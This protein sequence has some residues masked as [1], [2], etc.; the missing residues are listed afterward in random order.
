M[1]RC[2]RRSRNN[3]QGW[4]NYVLSRKKLIGILEI[5]NDIAEKARTKFEFE[6]LGSYL[7]DNGIKLRYSVGQQM[8]LGGG[9]ALLAYLNALLFA[10]PLIF[11]CLV[12]LAIGIVVDS[13]RLS[14][15][16]VAVCD[17]VVERFAF[18]SYELLL[19][20][21]EPVRARAKRLEELNRGASG[22]RIWNTY[23]GH[24]QGKNVDFSYTTYQFECSDR[25]E[26][27]FQ[28][29]KQTSYFYRIEFSP[30]R[31]ITEARSHGKGNIDRRSGI[32]VE[33]PYASELRISSEGRSNVYPLVYE[34]AAYDFRRSFS[35]NGRSEESLARFLNPAT[36]EAISRASRTVPGLVV[37]VSSDNLLC[38]STSKSRV[39][40][41]ELPDYRKDSINPAKNP[42]ALKTLIQMDRPM[43]ILDALLELAEELVRYHDSNFVKDDQRSSAESV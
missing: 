34:P 23:Q 4:I 11:L 26:D 24:Y 42:E 10:T 16:I 20:E 33:F 40:E 35:C 32:L 43:W 5:L 15:K 36:I 13:I 7:A 29:S 25:R 3:N 22:R 14:A 9:V 21:S 38:L 41:V 8:A 6:Q 1:D 18:L 27:A 2:Q 39:T 28:L 12:C 37:E 19:V 17:L 31:V 30:F